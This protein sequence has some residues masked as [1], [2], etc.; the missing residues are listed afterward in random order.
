M[1]DEHERL[2]IS[3]RK[4]MLFFLVFFLIVASVTPYQRILLSFLLGYVVGY[5]GLRFLPSRVKAFGEGLVD[6]GSC[7][8]FS[9]FISISTIAVVTNISLHS[10]EIII[11]IY[12]VFS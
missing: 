12:V 9:A 5:Y 4:W 10:Q 7:S 2:A 8:N 1:M 11:V 6:N 3:Q